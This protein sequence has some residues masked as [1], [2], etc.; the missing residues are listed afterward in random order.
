M[1]KEL[2]FISILLPSANDFIFES[3][4]SDRVLVVKSTRKCSH[5]NIPSS[6]F[7]FRRLGVCHYMYF[8]FQDGELE[9]NFWHTKMRTILRYNSIVP[10]WKP[11]GWHQCG[12]FFEWS[13]TN[14]RDRVWRYITIKKFWSRMKNRGC[15]D[16]SSMM[17]WFFYGKA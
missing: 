17:S 9:K 15:N 7:F 14:H 2:V 16:D 10:S 3:S 12:F 6:K 11:R 8:P 13:F 4:I 5:V 1:K